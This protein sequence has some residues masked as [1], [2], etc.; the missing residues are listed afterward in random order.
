M[1][2]TGSPAT[3]SYYLNTQFGLFIPPWVTSGDLP[4][5][6]GGLDGPPCEGGS[7]VYVGGRIPKTRVKLFGLVEYETGARGGL[8]TGLIFEASIPKTPVSVGISGGYNWKRKKGE[9]GAV[10]FA[11]GEIGK[12]SVGIGPAEIGILGDLRGSGGVYGG[13][14]F[15]GGGLYADCLG[16]DKQK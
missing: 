10:G 8:L 16:N 4:I 14:D 9:L 6:A 2:G 1:T 11:G 3:T 7:F 15:L 13:A 12:N 5:Q